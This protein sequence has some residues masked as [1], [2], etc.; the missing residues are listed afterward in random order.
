MDG[1]DSPVS[2]KS[3]QDLLRGAPKKHQGQAMGDELAIQG[4]ETSRKPPFPGSVREG[5]EGGISDVDRKNRALPDGL[6]ERGIVGEAQIVTEPDDRSQG[7]L[8]FTMNPGARSR[9]PMG[10]PRPSV[11]LVLILPD[12]LD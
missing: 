5:V 4:T 9:N 6:I 7:L 1:S 2:G 12:P 11:K 8:P 3:E 10:S